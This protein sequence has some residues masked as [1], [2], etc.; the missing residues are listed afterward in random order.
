M[1]LTKNVASYLNDYRQWSYFIEIKTLE[2]KHHLNGTPTTSE[3][4]HN[5]DHLSQ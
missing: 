1:L 5:D 4:D 3:D 2:N